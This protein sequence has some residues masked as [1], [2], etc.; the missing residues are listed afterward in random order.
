MVENRGRRGGDGRIRFRKRPLS[1]ALAALVWAALSAGAGASERGDYE[2]AWQFFQQGRYAEAIG[3]FKAYLSKYP[4]GSLS[5]EARFTLARIEPS[6]N[7]AFVHYQFILDNHP[8]HALASQASYATAQYYQNI[9]AISEA[10]ARYLATY[11]RYG[12][13]PAGSE[14]LYRLSL[15]SAQA[16]SLEAAEAYA[17]TFSEQYPANPR[18]PSLA[19]ALSER[20]QAGGDTGRARAGWRGILASFP[21]SFEAGAARERLLASMEEEADTAGIEGQVP[22]PEL[23]PATPDRR[24]RFLLQVGAYSDRNMLERWASR[25]TGRGYQAVVDSSE[26]GTRGLWKLRLGPYRTRDEAAEAS[27]RLKSGEGLEGII[28]EVR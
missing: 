5:A 16:D 25:L 2:Q 8:G 10:K 3:A 1:I 7:N 14:S 20:Y 6:G 27:R 24:G 18:N 12:Q 17:R 21:T 19:L 15:L 13:T 23:K 9:G 4:K 22:V 26:L 28:V 11:S